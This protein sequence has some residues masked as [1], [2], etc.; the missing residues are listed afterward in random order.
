MPAGGSPPAQRGS[1]ETAFRA[2]TGNGAYASF[3]EKIKGQLRPGMLADVLILSQNLFRL[4][5]SAIHET[6]VDLTV[7]N[8]RV[9]HARE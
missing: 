6:R 8:G 3:E 4:P 5:P 9:L 2:Y 7:F 1:V